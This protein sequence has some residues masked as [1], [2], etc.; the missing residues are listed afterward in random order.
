MSKF[1]FMSERKLFMITLMAFFLS[2][3]VTTNA[4]AAGKIAFYSNRDGNYEIYVL[5][6]ELK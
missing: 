3:L 6:K 5:N 2:L 1:I 4:S